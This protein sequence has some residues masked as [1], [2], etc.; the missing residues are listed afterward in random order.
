M[1]V[2]RITAFCA[3]TLI[4][5]WLIS[6]FI[7]GVY[8]GQQQVNT[9]NAM[10]GMNEWNVLGVPLVMPELGFWGGVRR[11]LMWDYSFFAGDF[12]YFKWILCYPISAGVVGGIF[13]I[14]IITIT[15][16]LH[17]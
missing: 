10:V 4:I 14:I 6:T 12:V 8:L 16:F 1:N 17:R 7:D 9:M 5:G 11:A 2:Y 15:S 13:A 3:F